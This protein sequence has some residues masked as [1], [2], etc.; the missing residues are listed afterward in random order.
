MCISLTNDATNNLRNNIRKNYDFDIRVYTFHK[1]A[2]EILKS[3]GIEYDIADENILDSVIDNFIESIVP[4]NKIFLKAYKNLA[5]NKKEELNLK[6][7]IKTFI[8]LFKANNY[9]VIY[10]KEILKKIKWTFNYKKYKNNKYLILFIL[11]IYLIYQNELQEN[12]MIDFN[13]M[14]NK[15]R[16]VVS[17]RGVLNNWQYIIVDEYQDTSL[18]KFNLLKE[19]INKTDANF[20]GVGDDFQSI[21]RFTGCDLNIFLNF[22]KYFP[23]GEVL[24]IINTYRNPQELINVTGSFVMKN[25][26]Q[27]KK[28]LVSS[29]HLDKPIVLYYTNSNVK[30]LKE[31]LKQARGE[32]FVI[33]R[34]NKDIFKYIDR[35]YKALENSY[36]SYENIKFRYLTAH[37]SKGLESDTVILINVCNDLLG[38]PTKIKD[39]EILKYVN[40]TKDIYPYEE[41]RRL[42][43]VAL[44][45]TKNKVYIICNNESIFIR[46]LTKYKKDVEIVKAE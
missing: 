6:R 19:I 13:D 39:E 12:N 22:K 45:R 36:Y 11:N 24:K 16:E 20:L 26:R 37:K 41:E 2:L 9:D 46:E 23:K 21:Y 10:F 31:L 42:F 7:L 44:T 1:L 18:T 29:K 15:C 14:I 34:N 3:H 32:I 17:K 40:N 8:N 33:G 5:S 38:F 35:E 4:T 27:L 30:A 28:K 25:P 43:Y